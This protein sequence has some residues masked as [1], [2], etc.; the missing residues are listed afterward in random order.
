MNKYIY[1]IQEKQLGTGHAVLV[2]ENSIDKD[3]D[4]VLVLVGDAPLVSP[5]TIL[6]LIEIHEK[7]EKD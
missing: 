1:S 6:K 7:N 4:Q 5:E 2:T 3:T